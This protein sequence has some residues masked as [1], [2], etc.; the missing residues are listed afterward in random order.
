M[1]FGGGQPW[2]KP[3][4][5]LDWINVRNNSFLLMPTFRVSFRFSLERMKQN[6]P[7]FPCCCC[8]CCLYSSSSLLSSSLFFLG[9]ELD[10]NVHGS[11]PRKHIDTS[12]EIA[13]ISSQTAT[14]WIT[15]S[16]FLSTQPN[17]RCQCREKERENPH[18]HLVLERYKS[19]RWW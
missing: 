17:R 12:T 14:E 8:C 15:E 7:T 2:V 11:F 1:S 10:S 18:L 4:A 16:C 6:L 19:S 13:I 9:R 3:C 5:T